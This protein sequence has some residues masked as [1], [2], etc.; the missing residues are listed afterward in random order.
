[1]AG[2]ARGQGAVRVWGAGHGP[3]GAGSREGVSPAPSSS[4]SLG[5]TGV[6]SGGW[7]SQLGEE[8]SEDG[9]R[10]SV[11]KTVGSLISGWT[12]R[13]HRLGHAFSLWS[14]N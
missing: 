4:L 14:G 10:A 3:A 8:D 11:L 1:M 7:G 6:G 9:Q 5:G 13:F 2:G 12:L